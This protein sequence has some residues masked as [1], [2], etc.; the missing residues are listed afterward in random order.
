[1]GDF[2]KKSFLITYASIFSVSKGFSKE[3]ISALL[4]EGLSHFSSS[5][6]VSMAG[7]R[8]LVLSM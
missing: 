3:A 4:N 2:F 8:C 1:M 5:S 7:I 6:R